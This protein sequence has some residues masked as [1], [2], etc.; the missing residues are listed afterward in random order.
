[1][2]AAAHISTHTVETHRLQS[3]QMLPAHFHSCTADVFF[4]HARTQREQPAAA[5]AASAASAAAEAAAVVREC[6][7]HFL[8]SFLNRINLSSKS[9]THIY[10]H[11]HT[12]THTR[13]H[14]DI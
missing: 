12:H 3:L 11:K 1:M 6:S 5:A 4:L 13:T 10:T 9:Y 14:A 7:V 2:P 8:F